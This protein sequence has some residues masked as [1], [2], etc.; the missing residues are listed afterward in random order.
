MKLTRVSMLKA[1]KATRLYKARH[2]AVNQEFNK[3]LV[4][5]KVKVFELEPTEDMWDSEQDKLLNRII[6]RKQVWFDTADKDK[7]NNWLRVNGHLDAQKKYNEANGI[8][9]K[10]I[11]EEY[12]E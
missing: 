2:P 4:T 10:V 12:E 11:E 7:Y 1:P 9:R 3:Y 6:V 5:G 8:I